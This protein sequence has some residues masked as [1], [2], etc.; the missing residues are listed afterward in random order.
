MSRHQYYQPLS[1]CFRRL[2]CARFTADWVIMG[3]MKRWRENTCAC[4]AMCHYHFCTP[5]PSSVVAVYAASLIAAL[6]QVAATHCRLSAQHR[7]FVGVLSRYVA[8]TG[9]IGAKVDQQPAIYKHLSLG[10]RVVIDNE[11]YSR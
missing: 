11:I 1:A 7:A 3:S 10:H 8:N 6:Q 4:R 2:H 9:P 5:P